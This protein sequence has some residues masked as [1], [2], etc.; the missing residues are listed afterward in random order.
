MWTFK[1]GFAA[2]SPQFRR[3]DRSPGNFDKLATY[4]AA[5]RWLVLRKPEAA[6]TRAQSTETGPASSGTAVRRIEE[7]FREVARRNFTRPPPAA[8]KGSKMEKI[9]LEEEVAWNSKSRVKLIV[10]FLIN[11]FSFLSLF[12]F[13]KIINK[14]FFVWEPLFFH[15]KID[16][17]HW[18]TN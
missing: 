12:L 17:K 7:E 2:Q 13:L 4:F 11:I 8:A 9:P 1:H 16:Y 14:F 15:G 18:K 5:F 3:A 6:G 10:C